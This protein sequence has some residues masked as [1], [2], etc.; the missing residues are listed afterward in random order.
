MKYAVFSNEADAAKVQAAESAAKGYPRCSCA[1]CGG[2][3]VGG[4]VHAPC[5]VP[6][7]IAEHPVTKHPKKAEWAYPVSAGLANAVKGDDKAK[8]AC[9]SA[10]ELA[11]DWKPA[12]K[13]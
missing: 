11:A 3:E 2:V 6:M 7:T 10:K 4:G 9:D 1:K 13:L 5:G 8:A 12:S